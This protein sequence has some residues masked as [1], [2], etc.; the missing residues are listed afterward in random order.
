M[1]PIVGHYYSERSGNGIVRVVWTDGK[2]V[3]FSRPK[4]TC[5]GFLRVMQSIG[6]FVT[7]YRHASTP[8]QMG[9][10]VISRVI[11][12]HESMTAKAMLPKIRAMKIPGMPATIGGLRAMALRSGFRVTGTGNSTGGPVAVHRHEREA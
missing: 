3:Q 4:A 2:H 12:L 11:G 9:C 1:V 8:E 5:F 10:D 6:E 7:R